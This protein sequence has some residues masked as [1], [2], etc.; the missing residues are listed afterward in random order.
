MQFASFQIDICLCD[1]PKKRDSVSAEDAARSGLNG[2]EQIF[3]CE[4]FRS[5]LNHELAAA[6]CDA[7]LVERIEGLLAFVAGGDQICI[8]Q[9]GQVM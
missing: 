3:G 8:A 5:E 9:D 4:G 6:K 7:F 1:L 2:L